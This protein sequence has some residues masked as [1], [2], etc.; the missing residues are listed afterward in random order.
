MSN[1][2]KGDVVTITEKSDYSSDRLCEGNIGVIIHVRDDMIG[3][4]MNQPH[5]LGNDNYRWYG[6]KEIEK[7][8]VL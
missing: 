1:L 6:R 4:D 7:I 8:G 2:K 3:V 5:V